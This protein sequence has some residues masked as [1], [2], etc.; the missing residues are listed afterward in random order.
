MPETTTS[1]DLRS[2]SSITF[3]GIPKNQMDTVARAGDD[4]I[5]VRYSLDSKL[6]RAG[7][8][9]FAAGLR[10]R[11][12]ACEPET[13]TSSDPRSA[14][15]ITSAGIPKNRMD[16]VVKA[17]GRRYTGPALARLH[18]LSEL[19]MQ[20]RYPDRTFDFNVSECRFCAVSIQN[21]LRAMNVLWEG[22]IFRDTRV[23]TPERGPLDT[24]VLRAPSCHRPRCEKA[25][26]RGHHK[27]N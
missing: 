25:N 8:S 5:P 12:G 9:R 22:P 18:F 3:A 20:I 21:R 7:M 6:C 24:A 17:G 23:T 4:E 1:S 14:S 15:S 11:T 16:T 10:P 26:A 19:N 13:T 27:S 2:A